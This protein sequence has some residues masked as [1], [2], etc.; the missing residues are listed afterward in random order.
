MINTDRIVPITKT[1]LLTAYGTMMKLAGTSVSA[2]AAS[3]P[4]EFTATGSGS[5]GNLLAAEPLKK[6][7]FASG[8]TAAVVY[9]VAD[10]DFDGFYINGT[11]EEP[12]G[13]SA[14]VN[15][16]GA[17]LYSATLASSDV[18]IAKVGF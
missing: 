17:T 1:D 4:G 12:A 5:I 14:T 2:L 3:A 9:F 15:K 18:T 11:Y 8:V 6:L 10:Y 13:G 16:D 7:N